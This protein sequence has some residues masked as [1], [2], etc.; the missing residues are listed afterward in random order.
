MSREDWSALRPPARKD[1][2]GA[3]DPR[4]AGVLPRRGGQPGHQ[5]SAGHPAGA[6]RRAAGLSEALLGLLAA[7]AA[8]APEV[9]SATTALA[10]H[11]QKVGAGVIIGSN[12][13]NLAALFG[14][15]GVVA[16]GIAL[17]RKVVPL[18]GMVG[19]WV[20]VVCLV[21]ITGTL[22]PRPAWS[23]CS[24]SCSRTS[25]C[26]ARDAPGWAACRSP[27][28]GTWLTVAFSRKKRS[29]RRSS[30]RR[31]A[32]PGRAGGRGRAGPR[33]GGQRGHGAV[34]DVGGAHFGVPQIVTGG[35]VLAAV[36][37]P[38]NAVA[39]VDWPPEAAAWPC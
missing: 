15:G 25:S 26:S 19:L 5:L 6:D 37:S 32:A 3:R 21:T 9:T 31:A 17:H 35:V 16:G 12:V 28:A 36:T 30:T 13:I 7:L 8:D 39:A 23:R 11:Q 33:G 14:L 34:R 2:A 18:G 38:A 29:W 22:R 20:A 4:A 24:P 27:G 1:A 10:Q